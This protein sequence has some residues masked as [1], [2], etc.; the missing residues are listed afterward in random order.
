[1][2]EGNFSPYA[3][4]KAEIGAV[5]P[6]KSLPIWLATLRVVAFLLNAIAILY[7]GLVLFDQLGADYQKTSASS[8]AISFGIALLLISNLISTLVPRSKRIWNWLLIAA[9]LF[10]CTLSLYD[11]FW[12]KRD[13]F[14]LMGF[15]LLFLSAVVILLL[16]LRARRD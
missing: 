15:A 10:V 13:F 2:S 9:N 3:A 6:A 12:G 5:L 11:F 7:A 1:M 4:P 16:Q 8:L 14:Q